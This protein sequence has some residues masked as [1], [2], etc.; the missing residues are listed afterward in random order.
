MPGRVTSIPAGRSIPAPDVP[1]PVPASP[2]TKAQASSQT[3]ILFQKYFKSVGQRTYAAQVSRARNDNQFITLIEGRRDKE[4]GEVKKSKLLVFSEDF[5]EFFK[6]LQD[7]SGWIK[8]HPLPQDFQEKR[9]RF[10]ATKKA[11]KVAGP[12]TAPALAQ[13]GSRASG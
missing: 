5:D 9:K 4:T 7:I 6:L 11:E 10:W 3:E 1:R 2:Q 8:Q 12:R 13:A